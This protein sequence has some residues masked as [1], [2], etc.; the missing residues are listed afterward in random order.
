[1]QNKHQLIHPLG[2]S[3]PSINADKYIL[4]KKEIQL[5]LSKQTLATFGQLTEA[6]KASLLTQKIPFEGSLTWH[7]EWVKLDMEARKQIIRKRNKSPH[8]YQLGNFD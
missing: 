8:Q 1:M 6:I 7:H 4:L 5:F 2:K 3:A